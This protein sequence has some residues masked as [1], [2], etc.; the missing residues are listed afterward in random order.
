MSKRCLI[1]STKSTQYELTAANWIEQNVDEL[2]YEWWFSSRDDECDPK[3]LGSSTLS[4][5]LPKPDT[6]KPLVRKCL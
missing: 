6:S 5:K 3:D 1:G 2:L 4:T